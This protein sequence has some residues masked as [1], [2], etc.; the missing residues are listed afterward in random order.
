MNT[1]IKVLEIFFSK[2]VESLFK[3]KIDFSL[4]EF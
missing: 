1:L 2:K 4:F 3:L